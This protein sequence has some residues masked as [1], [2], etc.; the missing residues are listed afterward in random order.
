MGDPGRR[1]GPPA[2]PEPQYAPP[3][4]VGAPP[5]YQQP[6]YQQPYAA[7][8]AAAPMSPQ[9]EKT[10]GMAAHGIALAATVFSGGFLSFVAALVMYLIVKDRGPFVR[11]H[12]ANALN[13]Q[14]LVGIV[15]VV[16]IP[17]MFVLIGFFTFA[18][19][20]VFAVVVHIV[21]II[22]ANNGEW[23]D[24]PMTPKFVR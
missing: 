19:A 10:W 8:V 4:A 24:P 13:V 3:Q 15:F 12:T 23:W 16:S 6:Q 5:Q 14:I 22:K 7:P 21:G 17:L 18:A 1:L 2:A 20:W 11:A 9:D